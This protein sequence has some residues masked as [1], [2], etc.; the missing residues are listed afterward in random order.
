VRGWYEW[1]TF[2]SC[3]ALLILF[4]CMVLIG[5]G[6]DSVITYLG[7]VAAGVLFG[8]VTKIGKSDK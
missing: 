4:G 3:A 7:C 8:N 5:L 6:R 1:A 2:S